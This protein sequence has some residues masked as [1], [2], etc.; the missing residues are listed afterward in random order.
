MTRATDEYFMN[1]ALQEGLRNRGATAE[2]PSVGCILVKDDHV[3]ARTVTAEGGRP[4]AEPQALQVAGER[5]RGATAYVTL[6]P[7]A[8]YGQTP[9]CA[10][11]LVV[12]GIA[13]VVTA[14]ED[15][16]PRTAGKGH[17]VL[18]VSGVNVRTGVLASQARENL[19]GFLS[20]IER[21][22][23]YVVLKMA[24][25]SDGKI[26][27]APGARTQITGE[28]ARDYVHQM[29]AQSDAIMIGAETAR[30]D[31]PALTC[32]LPGLEHRSPARIVVTSD[33]ESL[34]NL[35]MMKTR[36]DI[37]VWLLT[38]HQGEDYLTVDAIP[39]GRVDLS[40]GLQLFAKRG[41]NLL[42]VEGGALLAKSLLDNGLIDELHV[43]A[44]PCE[45]GENGVSS[46]ISAID[47]GNFSLKHS[48]PLG[49]DRL[50]VY[51]KAGV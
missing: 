50:S 22:R 38:T 49:E 41:I 20:R 12:A 8:H 31:D 13:R 43:I 24:Q 37:E 28:I 4:H 11:Q 15:P 40:Q 16:D 26:S 25:S 30:V 47:E 5:A 27:S 21:G 46:P 23:P 39:D 29:R 33:P 45:L 1:L 2:N 17:E 6:E 51:V 32:R 19:A 48:E 3:L 44:A 14:L 7:C 9:P 36:S 34:A 35:S 10:Q 42:M 18:R